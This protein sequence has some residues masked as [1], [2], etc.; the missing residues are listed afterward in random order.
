MP[1]AFFL[2]G[3]LATGLL[4]AAGLA[5]DCFP[6]VLVAVFLAAAFLVAEWGAVSAPQASATKAKV[7]AQIGIVRMYDV[8]V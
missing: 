6:A 3:V 4:A 1:E 7:A 2:A 8:T 5:G